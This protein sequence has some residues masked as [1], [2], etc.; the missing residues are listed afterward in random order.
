MQLNKLILFIWVS[1][2]SQ[3]T[4]AENLSYYGDHFYEKV[5]DYSESGQLK[6]KIYMIL[7]STHTLRHNKPDLI[8]PHCSTQKDCFSHKLHNYRDA[9]IFLFGQLHLSEDSQ[10]QYI[11]DVYCQ[12]D[13]RNSMLD[14]NKPLGVGKIPD[15]KIINAEHTWPQSR[16]S[17]TF[18]RRL[19]QSDLH[20]LFPALSRVNNLRSNLDFNEVNQIQSQICDASKKGTSLRLAGNFF[21]PPDQHK[22]NVARAIFYFSTRYQLPIRDEIEMIL[23]KWHIQDSVDKQEKL[24]NEKIFQFQKVRNPFIDH[25]WLVDYIKDF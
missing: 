18:S 3:Y 14:P 23:R 19:Q 11:L 2:F 13:I 10:G 6:K 9:R 24:R 1:L 5:R 25:A 7:S 20:A 22:G 21:E 15:P 4:T 17:N 12:L 16:F 8:S